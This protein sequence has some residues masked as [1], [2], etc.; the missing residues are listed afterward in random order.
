[1]YYYDV[2]KVIKIFSYLLIITYK[3]LLKIIILSLPIYV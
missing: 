1:M 3:T 2:Q